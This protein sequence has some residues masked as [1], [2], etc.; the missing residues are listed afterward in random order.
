MSA[1]VAE[2]LVSS[3]TALVPRDAKLAAAITRKGRRPG[4][5]GAFGYVN[6]GPL[7]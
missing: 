5:A 2:A 1:K 4:D 7:T 6:R 3:G